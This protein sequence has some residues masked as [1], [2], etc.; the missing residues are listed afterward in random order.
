M[1]APAIESVQCFGRKKTVVAVT[2]C[3]RGC[4]LIKINGYP[5]KLVE[6]EIRRFKAY[7]SI[8]LLRRQRFVGV[9]DILVRYD[10]T[11]FVADPQRCEPKKLGGHGA[12]ARFQKSY[13]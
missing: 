11:L 12:R 3:K 8:L 2:Y 5:I 13:R 7:E 4:S 6:P 1:A 9:E 10:M